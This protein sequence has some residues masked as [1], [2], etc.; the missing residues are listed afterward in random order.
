MKN[1]VVHGGTRRPAHVQDLSGLSARCNGRYLA[2]MVRFQ[3]RLAVPKVKD[4]LLSLNG[5]ILYELGKK[6]IHSRDCGNNQPRDCGPA[7][8]SIRE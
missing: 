7:L 2:G 3:T 5:G 6:W 1:P 4:A 8:C